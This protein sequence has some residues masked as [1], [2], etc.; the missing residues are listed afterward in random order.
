MS[1][2]N[3]AFLVAIGLLVAIA[4]QL[5]LDAHRDALGLYA[6]LLLACGLVTAIIIYSWRPAAK[7]TN[8]PEAGAGPATASTAG[9][10][11]APET[12]TAPES[13]RRAWS[14]LPAVGAL[15]GVVDALIGARLVAT[16]PWQAQRWW[17]AAVLIPCATLAAE[18]LL[19]GSPSAVGA[20]RGWWRELGPLAL[21][22]AVALAMRLPG[23]TTSPPFVHGDESA[24]G[25]Y[26]R[27]FIA[28]QAPLLSISW[29]GLPM[30]SYAISGVGLHLLGDSLTGLRLTN[31]ILG[32]VSVVLLYLLGRELFGR[33][34]AMLA[35]L[36]LAV[37][38]LDVD[39]SR[40]GIHYIQGPL[41]ITLT[42]YLLLRWWRRG[43]AFTAL[44]AGM[45]VILSLQVYWSG[46]VAPIFGGLLLA[47]LALTQRRVLAARWREIGWIA[48]GLVTAGAPVL[49]LFAS[50]AASFSGHQDD[51]NIFNG[52]PGMI[53]H[54]QSQYGTTNMTTI[55]LHQL[56]RIATTFNAQGDASFQIGWGGSMLDT[57]SAALLPA[58]VMLALLRWRRWQSTLCLLWFGAV[59]G[60]GVITIDP[61]W[62]PRLSALLPAVALL[63]G[64]LLADAAQ[65]VAAGLGRRAWLAAIGVA[66]LLVAIAVGNVRLVFQD[67][68]A[69]AVQS[70]PMEATLLGNFLTRAPG[71]TRAVLLSDGSLYIDYDVVQFLAPKAAGC[72]LMPGDPLNKCPFG[73]DSTLYILLPGRAGD[74]AWLRRQRPGGHLVDVGSYGDGSSRILAYE[75]PRQQA[76]LTQGQG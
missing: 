56:W 40:D 70:P 2:I 21:L 14:W 48:V 17:L 52:Q 58:A 24:C 30:L 4:L 61:P 71:A 12:T 74:V 57:V 66:A 76:S 63:L 73:T 5:R 23:I 53:G 9:T 10:A 28:G 62:W 65:V 1:D 16:A 51:V 36:I 33:G 42:L 3:R 26:G 47:Y 64:V 32:T 54:L 49:A 7:A 11:A 75:L 20:R 44:L 68:P 6:V 72:T 60:A 25:L 39:L 43:G 27:Q 22:V 45:S 15:I 13:R 19:A 35:G 29:Y 50:N 34:V 69:A 46:R 55:V 18:R 41:C 31:A 59:A 8:R 38:F 67:Y 37:T